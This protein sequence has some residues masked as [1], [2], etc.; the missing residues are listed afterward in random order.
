MQRRCTQSSCRRVF[1]IGR[2]APVRCPYC[3][4]TYPRVLPDPCSAQEAFG[5]SILA[6]LTNHPHVPVS[7]F[8]PQYQRW[9]RFFWTQPLAVGRYLSLWQAQ[10]I[11]QQFR[12]EGITADV[13][14]TRCAQRQLRPFFRI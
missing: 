1:P 8:F 12:R 14:S 6:D 3:G 4:T 10:Q 13:V 5:Y 9:P 11:C 2:T 7:R